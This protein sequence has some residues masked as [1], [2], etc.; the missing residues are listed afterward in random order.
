MVLLL[1]RDATAGERELR[2]ARHHLDGAGSSCIQQPG[3]SNFTA[4]RPPSPVVQL[5]H[6][7]AAASGLGGTAVSINNYC[8]LREQN[9]RS[10]AVSTVVNRGRCS[11]GTDCRQTQ[12]F[13]YT[14]MYTCMQFKFE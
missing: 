9:D 1:S 11:V 8:N 5:A 14:L 13:P 2:A 7:E 4:T 10:A 6:S 3:V 12:P